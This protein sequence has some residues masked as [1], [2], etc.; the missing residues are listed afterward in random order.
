MKTTFTI[1]R[2]TLA[3]PKDSKELATFTWMIQHPTARDILAKFGMELPEQFEITEHSNPDDPPDFTTLG[4]GFEVTEFPPNLSAIRAV[5]EQ[6]GGRAMTI[7]AFYRTGRS[8]QK[9]REEAQNPQSASNSLVTGGFASVV[10]E[11]TALAEEFLL[12][13]EGAK[14]KDVPGNDILL[15]DQRG[16][17]LTDFSTVPAIQAALTARKP[18]H[19]KLIIMVRQKESI[20]VFP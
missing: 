15:L 11:A 7:P 16:E 1:K 6:A 8:L 13:L 20:Q 12:L 3:P 10:D 4:C 19:I 9:I 2:D 17:G 5:Y 14:S 18:K